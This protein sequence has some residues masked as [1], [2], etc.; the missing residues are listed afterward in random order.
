[1]VDLKSLP[2]S[3]QSLRLSVGSRLSV[4]SYPEDFDPNS[5]DT[6]STPSSDSDSRVQHEVTVDFLDRASVSSFE[7]EFTPVSPSSF[8]Q[9]Y[10]YLRPLAP[11]LLALFLIA[12]SCFFIVSISTPSSTD[13]NTITVSGFNFSISNTF[14]HLHHITSHGPRPPGSLTLNSIVFPYINNTVVPELLSLAQSNG[15]QAG[16]FYTCSSGYIPY[17]PGSTPLPTGYSD[18]CT[19][20]ISLSPPLIP[21]SSPGL[22]L[23]THL[24]SSLHGAGVYSSGVHVSIGLEIIYSLASSFPPFSF[25]KPIHLS[26]GIG[27]EFGNI[28]GHVISRHYSQLLGLVFNLDSLG[29]G[30]TLV[31]TKW[32]QKY[33]NLLLNILKNS[34][35]ILVSGIFSDLFPTGLI[36]RPSSFPVF[37]EI[38]PT[39]DFNFVERS[40]I[41][42]SS[43][44]TYP[45]L[46]ELSQ[47]ANSVAA[48]AR[49][50][51]SISHQ[52][53]SSSLKF[54]DQNFDENLAFHA[55]SRFFGFVISYLPAL[56]FNLLIITFLSIFAILNIKKTLKFEC[57]D[58]YINEF[59]IV[60]SVIF[61][62]FAPVF[63][64]FLFSLFFYVITPMNFHGN[65][66][67]ITIFYG[68]IVLFVNIFVQNFVY[69]AVGGLNLIAISVNIIPW[70]IFYFF[71]SI[72]GLG[73]AFNFFILYFISNLPLFL[74]VYKKNNRHCEEKFRIV[75]FVVFIFAVVLF[76]IFIGPEL[77]MLCHF[78]AA[79]FGAISVGFPS[80]L[81]YSVVIGFILTFI[82]GPFFGFYQIIIINNEKC[83]KF[84][85]KF[86]L[87]LMFI[88]FTVVFFSNVSSS[89]YPLKISLQHEILR[90]NSTSRLS[91]Q[92]PNSAKLAT[93][94]KLLQKFDINC[95]HCQSFTPKQSNSLCVEADHLTFPD[96]SINLI[97]YEIDDVSN[98]M[99]FSINIEAEKAGRLF[100]IFD[101][102]L[103]ISLGNSSKFSNY[104]VINF[105][106]D[107]SVSN[108]H[109]SVSPIVENLNIK[110][111]SSVY[112][113]SQSLNLVTSKLSPNYIPWSSSLLTGPVVSV[114]DFVLV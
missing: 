93:I 95:Y 30:G 108:W 60:S 55:S 85:S 49:S 12:L 4:C 3:S 43:R 58:N 19:L 68:L 48:A 7:K 5:S 29:Y 8:E 92:F 88:F 38:A 57:F 74:I 45:S 86:L 84:W 35:E 11:L 37:S 79:N 39:I 107:D 6:E 96:P 40:V 27:G 34:P 105:G 32:T 47:S 13:T 82:F 15:W 10:E 66:C 94:Q 114:Y 97:D 16:T 75:V 76:S 109:F 1:M 69:N 100:F 52:I 24:D 2:K 81:I 65:P 80:D 21:L 104:F 67:I 54:S 36:Q 23:S 63:F 33:S 106:K 56:V 112:I 17:T 53:L 28:H 91:I 14:T 18:F 99:N 73:S 61:I 59:S 113:Q 20:I 90:Q 101:E 41:T 9:F 70:F 72:I 111:L 89:K 25:N 98:L 64:C 22:F 62:L 46:S 103:N 44:D 110:L 78:L 87:A 50:L 77:Y 42:S 71:F 83:F 26:I 31:A 51:L 102:N